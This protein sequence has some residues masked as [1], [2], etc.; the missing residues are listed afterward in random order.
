MVDGSQEGDRPN[1]RAVWGY[2]G[3]ALA[4]RVCS[5]RHIRCN[6]LYRLTVCRE[7]AGGIMEEGLQR[8]A[9]NKGAISVGA[10]ANDEECDI[11]VREGALCRWGERRG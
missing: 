11:C 6:N 10:C 9:D 3:S 8:G 7:R 2:I 5:S 4:P 1:R